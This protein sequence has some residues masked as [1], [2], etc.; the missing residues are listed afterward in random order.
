MEEEGK[1]EEGIRKECI[2]LLRKAGCSEK[3]IRHCI[4][5][6]ELAL[7][8]YNNRNE[9]EKDNISKELILTGALLHDI[10]RAYSHGIDH[11]FIGG[12]VARNLGL[13]EKVVHIIQRHVGAGITKK[14]AKKIGFPEMDFMPET[15]EEKIVAHADNL[16]D[17]GRRIGMEEA[18]KEVKEKL[19]EKHPSVERMKKLHMEVIGE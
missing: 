16:I 11:G 10:G 6:A 7:K 12:E 18:I 9:D 14:E 4:A 5:V 13:D 15:M 1:K 2:E 19:G 8:I 17:S 3:V